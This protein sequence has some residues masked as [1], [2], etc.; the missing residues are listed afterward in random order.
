MKNKPIP[1]DGFG[2]KLKELRESKSLRQEYV[3]GEMQISRSF[4]S[5]I[6]NGKV[7]LTLACFLKYCAILD[8]D[9]NTVINILNQI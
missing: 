5:K 1:V 9:V 8:I 6:E 7:I 3:A 4:L 2:A